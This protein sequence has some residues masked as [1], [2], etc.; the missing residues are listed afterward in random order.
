MGVLV[1]NCGSSSVKFAHFG[2]SESCPRVHGYVEEIGSPASRGRYV[3]SAHPAQAIP[4][5]SGSDH[6]TALKAIV[7]ILKNTRELSDLEIHAVGHR[8]VHGGQIFSDPV[9]VGARELQQI[10]SL[11][12]LAPVHAEPNALGIEVA[13]EEL[14]ETPQIAVFDTGFHQTIPPRVHRY[15]VAESLYRDHQVRRYGFHG[16]SHQFVTTEACRI[17]DLDV[18]DSLLISAHLGNGC[19]ATAVRH[20]ASVDTT[21]GLTPLEGLP[22]GTRSGNVDPN[23]HAYLAAQTGMSLSEIT[24]MLNSES[25]LLGVSGETNDMRVLSERHAQGCAASKLAI[26]IFCFRLAREIAGL[27]VALEGMPHALIFTGGIGENSVLVRQ[28]TLGHLRHLGF[29]LDPAANETHGRDRKGIITHPAS[30]GPCALVVATNEELAI[31]R[32]ARKILNDL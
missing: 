3:V 19:S 15:A 26:E 13:M 12:P 10:R 31:A 7:D 23:L 20:G 9:Q 22:M 14:P 29:E 5:P 25:G 18:N 27:T 24:T 32:A 16:T 2:D 30:S 21:M 6:S 4:L 1:I 8:V 28:L 11:A 17:L